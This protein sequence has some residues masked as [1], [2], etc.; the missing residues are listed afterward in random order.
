LIGDIFDVDFLTTDSLGEL[1]FLDARITIETVAMTAKPRI[2]RIE[3][4]IP[5]R[6]P[7]GGFMGFLCDACGGAIIFLSLSRY[8]ARPI[9]RTGF[10][11]AFM[12]C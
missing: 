1:S 8:E 2:H 9:A 7:L 11:F 10:S 4:R 6:E 5:F 3:L 12:Q